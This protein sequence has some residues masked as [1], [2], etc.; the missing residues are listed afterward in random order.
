[1]T[2]RKFS[3]MFGALFVLYLA[4]LFCTG[5]AT[6]S[7]LDEKTADELMEE[8]VT[9]FDKGYYQGSIDSFQ[10]I[11]DR[12]PYSKHCIDAE[13]KLADA[14]YLKEKYDEGFNAYNEFQRLHP[15]NSNIPYVIFQKGMCHFKQVS[16]NDRD[17]S[18]TLF[19]REEFERL[20]KN[21]P[22]SEYTDRAQWKMREC[23]MIL[24][25]NELYV[26]HF[27][28]KNQKY[29]A[30]MARY[31]YVLENYP[32]LGQYHEALEYLGK[33]KERLAQGKNG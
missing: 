24:A 17:Q 8:G 31:R 11:I 21:F 20:I 2:I 23:Y 29:E 26:G 32:D 25:E 4:V 6:T 33:C 5:C 16:T 18:H 9:N 3:H 1:M 13:L 27:Y 7:K 14:L 12:Y 30:A 28:F 10:K 15:K 22:Q 19:A